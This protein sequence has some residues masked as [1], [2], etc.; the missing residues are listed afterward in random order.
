LAIF[1]A[2]INAFLYVL[3]PVKV[4]MPGPVRHFLLTRLARYL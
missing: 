3:T 4:L 1:P 2:P